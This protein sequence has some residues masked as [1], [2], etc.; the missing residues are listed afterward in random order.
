M[1]VRK[2]IFIAPL[3][4]SAMVILA[5][6]TMMWS[7][8]LFIDLVCP[9]CPI[10]LTTLPH[11]VLP[12]VVDHTHPSDHITGTRRT[13]KCKW[14]QLLQIT[15]RV[16]GSSDRIGS[17]ELFTHFLQILKCDHI[18]CATEIVSVNISTKRK[19]KS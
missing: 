3:T 4:I 10:P 9:L 19:V 8:H 13:C 12:P 5:M 14:N 7:A 2:V 18:S 16:H 6:T 15:H 17:L 11:L 1:L